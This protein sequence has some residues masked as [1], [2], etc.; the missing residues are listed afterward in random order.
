MGKLKKSAYRSCTNSF[1]AQF[2]GDIIPQLKVLFLD[3]LERTCAN[4]KVVGL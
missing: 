4:K 1:P 2:F 3:T